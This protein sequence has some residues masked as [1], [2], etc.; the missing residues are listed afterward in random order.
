M[1][2]LAQTPR[3]ELTD[4]E[5]LALLGQVA[6]A[7]QL[8]KVA[9]DTFIASQAAN[10]KIQETVKQ[11]KKSHKAYGCDLSPALVWI[12]CTAKKAQDEAK[13]ELGPQLNK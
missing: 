5:K 7:N 11:L 10:N 13:A 9:N 8:L 12:D 6:E 3:T 4:K 1:S 2:M